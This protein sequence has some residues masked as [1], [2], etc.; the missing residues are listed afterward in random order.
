MRYLIYC[1]NNINFLLK[2][3]I[4]YI[5]YEISYSCSNEMMMIKR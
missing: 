2:F 4:F 3:N 5:N 1:K